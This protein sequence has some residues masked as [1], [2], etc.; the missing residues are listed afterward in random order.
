MVS[1]LVQSSM[2][3]IFESKEDEGGREY[4]IVTINKKS[5][6][7]VFPKQLFVEIVDPEKVRQEIEEQMEKL[8]METMGND[9]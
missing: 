7:Q 4:E 8:H 1:E 5:M 3:E 2:D 9:K 6:G